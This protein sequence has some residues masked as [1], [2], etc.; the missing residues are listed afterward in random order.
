VPPPRIHLI[1][2]LTLLNAALLRMR[3]APIVTV[4]EAEALPDDNL[5]AIV[6]MTADQVV[7]VAR[8]MHG[9]TS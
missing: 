6:A 3:A 5:A 4:H 7:T 9:G 1:D 2:K 8:A